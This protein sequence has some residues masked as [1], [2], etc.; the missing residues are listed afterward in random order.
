MQIYHKSLPASTTKSGFAKYFH[1][2][3]A[4][5]CAMMAQDHEAPSRLVPLSSMKSEPLGEACM[6]RQ[7]LG[8]VEEYAAKEE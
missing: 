7:L 5:P 2:S 6:V 8:D 1:F 3:L 4:P